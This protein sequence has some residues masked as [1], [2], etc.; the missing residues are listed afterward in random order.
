MFIIL[1]RGQKQL[2]IDFTFAKML[3]STGNVVPKAK[4]KKRA[5]DDNPGHRLRVVPPCSQKWFSNK[6]SDSLGCFY[7]ETGSYKSGRTL[8]LLTGKMEL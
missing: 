6:N 7:R 1:P 2:V 5:I 3:K 8:R 4:P